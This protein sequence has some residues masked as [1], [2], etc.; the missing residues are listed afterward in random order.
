MSNA[1]I[2]DLRPYFKGLGL[3]EQKP[4]QLI[5]FAEA[6]THQPPVAGK[7][8]A[9]PKQ[10]R[11]PKSEISHLPRI[12]E[13]S[14]DSWKLYCREEFYKQAKMTLPGDGWREVQTTDKKLQ[15]YIQYLESMENKDE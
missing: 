3:H 8:T 14:L 15:A 2:D 12:G 13:L 1:T 7:L 11:F 4:P 6:W 5:A 9:K 10:P